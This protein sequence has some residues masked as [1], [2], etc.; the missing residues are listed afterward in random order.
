MSPGIEVL[1][2]V[3]GAGLIIAGSAAITWPAGLLA[4]GVLLLLAAVDVGR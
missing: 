3:L 4:A 1:L 2:L